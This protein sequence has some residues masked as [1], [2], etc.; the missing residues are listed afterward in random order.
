[1]LSL[2][3]GRP[4]KYASW[5]DGSAAAS[6]HAG[7]AEPRSS[8]VHCLNSRTRYRR[9]ERARAGK[10]Y[11]FCES[12]KSHLVEIASLPTDAEIV[13]EWDAFIA[14]VGRPASQTRLKALMERG[15]HRAGDVENRL[16]YYVGQ[17]GAASIQDE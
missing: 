5:P 7:T 10:R 8:C 11:A 4:T 9:R 16:G 13:P 2:E 15:F 12:G 3:L 1:M 17:V 14:S 6:R